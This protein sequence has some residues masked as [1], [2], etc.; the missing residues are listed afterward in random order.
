MVARF[1]VEIRPILLGAGLLMALQAQ[2]QRP[3][4]GT[5]LGLTEPELQATFPGVNRMRKPL[6]GP[7][8]VRGLWT[9]ANTP[10]AGLPFETTFYMKD[11]RVTRI[12]QHWASAAPQCSDDS[13]FTAL[14]SRMDSQYGVGLMSS[15]PAKDGLLQRSAV[16]EAGEFDVLSHL[17]HAPGQCAIRVIYT[18]HLVKDASEL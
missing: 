6:I 8:G 10:V 13:A 15:D 2:A 18:A 12:E 11:K 5:L 4:D 9:L 3:L 17:T 7:H 16:W 14:V 1:F